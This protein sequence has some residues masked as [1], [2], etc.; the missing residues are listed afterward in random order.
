MG[1]QTD[2]HFA[3]AGVSPPGG[4]GGVRAGGWANGALVFLWRLACPRPLGRAGEW[5]NNL[6]WLAAGERASTKQVNRFLDASACCGFPMPKRAEACLPDVYAEST[7]LVN[8]YWAS[9]K[10]V[11]D[12]TALGSLQHVH[13]GSLWW[14]VLSRGAVDLQDAPTS[15]RACL[16]LGV[17]HRR[18]GSP[19]CSAVMFDMQASRR[20]QFGAHC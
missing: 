11:G 20:I 2:F 16:C 18:L 9:T 7:V 3:A 17:S 4:S 8:N 15:V 12:A 5:A 14:H 10:R 1:G 6:R 19:R 13:S